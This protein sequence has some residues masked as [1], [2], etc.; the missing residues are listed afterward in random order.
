MGR[1]TKNLEKRLKQDQTK[2]TKPPFVSF[3]STTSGHIQKNNAKKIDLFDFVSSS[4]GGQKVEPQQVIDRLLSVE[5]EQDIINGSVPA[6]SLRL[7][8]KVWCE[9]GKPHYSGK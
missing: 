5:D 9:M 6:E 2:L 8:I 3:V 1:W 4:C 7:H